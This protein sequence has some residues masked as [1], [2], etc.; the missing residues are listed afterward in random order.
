MAAPA[1]SPLPAPTAQAVHAGITCHMGMADHDAPAVQVVEYDV[2]LPPH[3]GDL[4]RRYLLVCEQATCVN[5]AR[6]HAEAIGC[7]HDI[8][9]LTV[10]DAEEITG[11]A[12][13]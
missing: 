10:E 1:T 4:D 7:R 11:L 2:S 8:Y 13:A 9:L 5:E 6:I 12:V 3:A